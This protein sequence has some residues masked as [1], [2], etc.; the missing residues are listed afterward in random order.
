MI[1]TILNA[2]ADGDDPAEYT[3]E[4]SA[5]GK[6]RFSSDEVWEYG[7]YEEGKEIDTAEVCTAILVKRM[8]RY[9]LPYSVY[10]R[11]TEEQIIQKINGYFCEKNGYTGIWADL[12]E[13]A[14]P[15]VLEYLKEEKYA[16]DEAYCDAFFKSSSGKDVSSAR[17]VFELVRRGVDRDTAER[18]GEAAGRDDEASCRRALEKKLRQYSEQTGREDFPNAK[19]RA[20]ITRFLISRGF[21]PELINK[22][23]NGYVFR[24]GGQGD[25]G[26]DPYGDG[27]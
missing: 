26:G 17:L 25:L 21:E 27:V 18:A 20:S 11:R 5:A 14:L 12:K 2:Q 24:E 9:V 7:L 23:L 4:F 10:C 16:G 8:K 13:D 3:V 19:E 6:I 22:V 1:E 15:E